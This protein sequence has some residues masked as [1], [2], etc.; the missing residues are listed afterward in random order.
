MNMD[1]LGAK[2]AQAQANLAKIQNLRGGV[3]VGRG[4]RHAVDG[5]AELVLGDGEVSIAAQCQEALS[6]VPP[7]ARQQDADHFPP[8]VPGDALEKDIHRRTVRGINGSF[9]ISDSAMSREYQMSIATAQQN[10][11]RGWKVALLREP[12]A[13]RCLVIEPVGQRR[14]ELRINMLNNDNGGAESSRKI[15]EQVRQ[16]SGT[17]R[18]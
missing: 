3:Q 18:R 16:G 4:F 5:T 13:Q 8:P 7:H 17:A 15:A 6:P 2:R 9:A 11:A 14:G 1:S 12:N 10:G